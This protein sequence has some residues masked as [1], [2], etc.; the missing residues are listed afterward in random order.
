MPKYEGIQASVNQINFPLLSQGLNLCWG[1][2]RLINNNFLISTW[3][4]TSCPGVIYKG[5]SLNYPQ[6]LISH[7]WNIRFVYFLHWPINISADTDILDINQ[8]LSQ[9]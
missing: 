2:E 6:L 8:D 3:T 1:S 7:L 4:T 5:E 9:I